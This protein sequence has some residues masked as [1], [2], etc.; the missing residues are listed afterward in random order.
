M[1]NHKSIRMAW[2]DGREFVRGELTRSL[3]RTGA[4]N[5]PYVPYG[6]IALSENGFD[7]ACYNDNSLADL[8]LSEAVR[9]DKFD[10]ED[11]NLR[12]LEWAELI[13]MAY[14]A[15]LWDKEHDE[16]EQP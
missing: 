10:C 11:W 2:R 9:S 13:G 4:R 12:P 6:A 16:K 14:E 7:A 3:E 1:K 15:L 8:D 5:P